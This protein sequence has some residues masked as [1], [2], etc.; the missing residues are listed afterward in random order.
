[1]RQAREE[2]E[3]GHVSSAACG[4]VDC[5]VCASAAPHTLPH[6]PHQLPA[7]PAQHQTHT[8]RHNTHAGLGHH[9]DAGS[10]T[11]QQHKHIPHPVHTLLCTVHTHTHTPAAALPQQHPHNSTP[12]CAWYMLSSEAI[13]FICFVFSLRFACVWVT[14]TAVT[15]CYTPSSCTVA[16]KPADASKSIRVCSLVALKVCVFPLKKGRG[17]AEQPKQNVGVPLPQN[18]SKKKVTW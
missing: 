17:H 14:C 4:R 8:S 18:K 6:M 5:C 11:T 3:W 15:Q 2:R 10:D 16:H 12:T 9:T 7:T 1:M 13:A